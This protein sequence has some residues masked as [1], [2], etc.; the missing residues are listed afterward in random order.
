MGGK[1]VLECEGHCGRTLLLDE[2]SEYGFCV[3]CEVEGGVGVA[4]Y[5]PPPKE[6][7]KDKMSWESYLPSIT[8]GA[9][10][11]SKSVRPTVPAVRCTHYGLTEVLK[12]EGGG[13]I[14][15]GGIRDNWNLSSIDLVVSL[16]GKQVDSPF[17]A[18]AGTLKFLGKWGKK[19]VYPNPPC[20][21]VDWSDGDEPPM[22]LEWFESLYEYVSSQNARVLI[23][24]HG[25]HGRT[26]TALAILAHLYGWKGDVVKTLR[27]VYCAKAVESSLQM[28]WLSINGVQSK[29][30]PSNTPLLGS[31]TK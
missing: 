10:K 6:E 21:E 22:D 28:S 5:S 23:H 3:N 8:K 18:S 26:G 2:L 12:F 9:V 31:Y 16:I 19:L 17:E 7:E 27:E 29:E 15:A 25:G 13:G 11:S 20:I 4:G 1:L 24:C 14:L 30:K